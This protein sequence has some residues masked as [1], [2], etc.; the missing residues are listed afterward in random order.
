MVALTPIG[1]LFLA[2]LWVGYR[3]AV[4]LYNICPFHPLA[5][6]PGPKIAAASYPYEAYYDWLLGGRY[7]HKIRAMHERHGE[8]TSC[9]ICG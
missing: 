2:G 7:G 9:C 3:L 8:S 1:L 4:A 5:S 6:F